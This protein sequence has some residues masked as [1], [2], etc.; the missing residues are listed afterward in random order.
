MKSNIDQLQDYLHEQIPL[1]QAMGLWVEVACAEKVVLGASLAKNLNHKQT[2]FGGSLNALATLACWGLL[3]LNLKS[4]PGLYEVVIAKGEMSFLKPVQE[5]LKAHSLLSVEN[6]SWDSFAKRLERK[7]RA[8]IS[9]ESC[10]GNPD[11]P[12][13]KFLG[14]FVA[15]RVED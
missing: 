7:G 8:R 14:Q 1:T 3:F 13:A 2:A 10:I 4:I 11:S 9:L 5:D 6:N 15:I 12:A